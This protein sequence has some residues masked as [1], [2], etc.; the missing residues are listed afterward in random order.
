MQINNIF[1]TYGTSNAENVP[2]VMNWLSKGA[3]TSFTLSQ[4]ESKIHEKLLM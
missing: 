3:Y 2:A 1:M 4:R